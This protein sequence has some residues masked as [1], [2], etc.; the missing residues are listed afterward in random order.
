MEN[1]NKTFCQKSQEK[2]TPP[3]VIE[4]KQQA[5]DEGKP[6]KQP[7]TGPCLT[8]LARTPGEDCEEQHQRFH[9]PSSSNTNL[10]Q[11][12]AEINPGLLNPRDP[13][14]VQ[15]PQKKVF[16]ILTPPDHSQQKNIKDLNPNPEKKH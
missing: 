3:C 14:L 9:H 15:N 16:G 10:V 11:K 2:N 13:Q 8:A 12:P 6:G 1:C 7:S 4:T 5:P